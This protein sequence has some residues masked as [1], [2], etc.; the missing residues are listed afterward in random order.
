[1][2]R[3]KAFRYAA[4]ATLVVACSDTT[5]PAGNGPG[6][7][8]TFNWSGQIAPGRVVEIKNLNGDIRASRAA[9]SAVRVVA[10]KRGDR[11]HPSTVRIEVR[12]TED[13]VTVCALYPDVSGQPANECLP[14]LDGQQSTWRNDVEVT[15]DVEVPAGTDFVGRTLAG[16]VE[17]TALDGDVTARSVSGDID[18]ST[19]GLADG[20]TIQGDVTASIGRA[21]PDRD[22]VFR[23]VSGHVTVHVPAN[24]SAEVW[25]TTGNG[26]ISTDFPLGITRLGV[27][28]QIR[29]TLGSGG[30]ALRLTTFEGNIA[31][32]SN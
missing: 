28:R 2:W 9:G 31:L 14:G 25:G 16:S 15:F 29:G 24:L 30:H 26:S 12:E 11:D 10:L 19:S 18:I 27:G 21:V 5:G 3:H 22:L 1:M 6:K 32:R 17:A 13:G 23:S 20:V 8:E 7:T 4:I